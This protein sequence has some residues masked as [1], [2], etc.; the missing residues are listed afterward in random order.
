MLCRAGAWEPEIPP[1]G[2]WRQAA[3]PPP[4]EAP[5]S[6]QPGEGLGGSQGSCA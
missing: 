2:P 1:G 5:D 4:S 6:Q 3:P